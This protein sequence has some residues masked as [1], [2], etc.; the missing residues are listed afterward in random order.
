MK[1]KALQSLNAV[2][3]NRVYPIELGQMYCSGV[4][5]IDGI[6]TFANGLYPSK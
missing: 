4:R 1:D 5:T 2:K 6:E 3:N